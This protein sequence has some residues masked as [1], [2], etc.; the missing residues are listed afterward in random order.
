MF[1][2]TGH[3]Q[4]LTTGRFIFVLIFT[5]AAPTRFN[6]EKLWSDPSSRKEVPPQRTVKSTFHFSTFY[7][8][9]FRESGE[10][11]S[12]TVQENRV[13]F[14]CCFL[15]LNS[16][17]RRVFLVSLSASRITKNNYRIFT[18][19]QE[20]VLREGWAGRNQTKV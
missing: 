5:S 19:V 15:L 18:R 3:P 8:F 6:L 7:I 9:C 17:Q 12:D 14:S 20:V 1:G 16:S 13:I 11:R 10:E 4:R 2:L